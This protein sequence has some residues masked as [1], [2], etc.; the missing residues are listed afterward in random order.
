ML[1]FLLRRFSV[2]ISAKA[3]AI[4]TE[5]FHGFPQSPLAN[6]RMVPQL[7]YECFLLILFQFI[8]HLALYSLGTEIIK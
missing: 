2:R 1:Q 7:G 3:L 5:I 6:A 8:S 4:L